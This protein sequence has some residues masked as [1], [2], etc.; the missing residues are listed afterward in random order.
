MTESLK[1]E[2][3]AS[4]NAR[5]HSKA[6]VG[7]D[8]ARGHFSA[9]LPRHSSLDHGL[10]QSAWWELKHLAVNFGPEP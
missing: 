3:L 4:W 9:K 7:L 6:A 8:K 10:K 1:H 2:F 5:F